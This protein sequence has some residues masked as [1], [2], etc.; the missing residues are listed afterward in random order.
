MFSASRH[1]ISTYYQ[2]ESWSVKLHVFIRSVIVPWRKVVDEIPSTGVLLDYGCGHGLFL[3]YCKIFR[4]DLI[5]IGLEPDARK[6]AVL[7]KMKD[8]R[9]ID[10]LSEIENRI[11]CI[12]VSDVFYAINPDS[13]KLLLASLTNYLSND[14]IF[15][16][17]EIVNRPRIK[18][19]FNILH[20]ML[21][22]KM[23]GVTEGDSI[24]LLPVRHYGSMLSHHFA[25]IKGSAIDDGYLWPHYLFVCKGKLH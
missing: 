6:K 4:P 9:I 1:I 21:T 24:N 23:F 11:D 25:V 10:N 17:K 19:W 3:C 2:D 7:Q 13:H 12:V 14:G 22:M 18:Y 16:I 15:I 20:E 8:V 5:L